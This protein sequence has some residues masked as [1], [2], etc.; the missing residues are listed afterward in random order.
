MQMIRKASISNSKEH[1]QI[2]KIL[3][4]Q[5]KTLINA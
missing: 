4:Q 2:N 1:A 3:Q 5:K